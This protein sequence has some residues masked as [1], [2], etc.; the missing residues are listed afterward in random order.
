MEE[1]DVWTV[2]M[3][4][5]IGWKT[6]SSEQAEAW[7]EKKEAWIVASPTCPFPVGP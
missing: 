1:E 4:A 5:L 6:A 3:I 2:E 7:V